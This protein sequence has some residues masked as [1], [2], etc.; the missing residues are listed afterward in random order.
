MLHVFLNV[1]LIESIFHSPFLLRD[2]DDFPSPSASVIVSMPFGLFF[3]FP[4][5]L[6][7]STCCFKNY[8]GL[9]VLLDSGS[10]YNVSHNEMVK[11]EIFHYD[12][13]H[14]PFCCVF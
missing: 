4:S 13:P 12:L 6:R 3:G 2:E 14:P 10:M 9:G 7:Y 1:T 5:S 8:M 11:K